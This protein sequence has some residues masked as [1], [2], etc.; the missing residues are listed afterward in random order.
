MVEYARDYCSLHTHIN[1]S[2]ALALIIC[3]L[4]PVAWHAQQA[5]W[6]RKSRSW[7]T[8]NVPRINIGN[9][10]ACRTRATKI[11]R[12]PTPTGD[13]DVEGDHRCRPSPA[14]SFYLSA[15]DGMFARSEISRG[16]ERIPFAVRDRLVFQSADYLVGKRLKIRFVEF[17]IAWSSPLPFV[18]ICVTFQWLV[19]GQ[20]EASTVCQGVTSKLYGGKL[21]DV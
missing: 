14:T 9:P 1:M 11:K 7:A 17:S 15:N 13:P 12:L 4:W 16:V 5:Y 8:L 10:N 3:A 21:D 19:L 20:L 6:G 2:T 18:T